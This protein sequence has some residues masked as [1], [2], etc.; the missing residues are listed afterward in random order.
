MSKPEPAVQRQAP[1]SRRRLRTR[2]I[3]SFALLGF[4]LT[5]LFA[6]AMLYLRNRLEAQLIETTLQYEVANLV[7][8]VETR[9]RRPVLPVFD[10]HL[11]RQKRRQCRPHLAPGRHEVREG[12]PTWCRG[13]QGRG[14]GRTR[15]E[16]L[17]SLIR[18][19]VTDAAPRPMC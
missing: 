5:L 10:D 1:R 6:V 8:H 4:G 2:I 3:V 11:Q 16:A 14:G 13:L 9:H 17:H 15:R 19:T 7:R 18:Y 12:I